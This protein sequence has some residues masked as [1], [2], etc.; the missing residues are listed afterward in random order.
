MS[1]FKKDFSKLLSRSGLVLFCRV[2]GAGVAFATQIM[3]ARWMGASELGIYVYAFSLAMLLSTVASLGFPAAS[4]R[5][6]SLYLANRETASINGFL[7]KGR[8]VVILSSLAVVAI[9]WG[10]LAFFI[11]AEDDYYTAILTGLMCIPFITMF[12]FHDRIAHVFS[13]FTLSFF[14]SMTIR[15]VLFLAALFVVWKLLGHLSADIALLVQFGAI[16]VVVSGQYLLLR[17]RIKRRIN[18]DR[19]EH[20][21]MLW[22]R[23]SF[24]L[25]IVTIFTQYFPEL[26][27]ILIGM[28]MAPD[29]VAIYNASY[30]AALLIA[31]VHNAV[32]A[33]IVPKATQLYAQ[34]DV[35]GLQHYITRA[36]QLNFSL[37]L[38]GFVVFIFAGE[39]LL[40]FFG[41]EFVVGYPA[42]LILAGAQL[43]LASVGP[44]AILLNITGHQNH[45][46]YVF[47]VSILLT[48]LLKYLLIPDF[49]ILGAAIMVLLVVV[50]WATWLHFLV[51]RCLKIQ[52]SILSFM[53]SKQ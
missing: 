5:F 15:P 35:A 37:S 46:L 38:V 27:V 23:G 13:W 31:F 8:Q 30:R 20:D 6:I 4:L 48:V 7:G 29:K 9:G 25:L 12:R 32:S 24:P 2:S 51:V 42:L 16:V 34:G 28:D 41:E 39:I 45:C 43:F 14:P 52:P 26:T 18:D 53:L 21:L 11:D 17:P 10:I 36:T 50:F 44:V 49:G 40:G 22:L 1:I 33:A 47:G 3:M 19:V